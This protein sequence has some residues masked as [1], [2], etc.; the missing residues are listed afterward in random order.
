MPPS[1]HSSSS[2]SSSSHSSHSSHSSS[3][4]SYSSHSYN[5]HSS[6]SRSFGSS[7]YSGGRSS[8]SRSPSPHSSSSHSS[9]P[10]NPGSSSYQQQS[11]PAPAPAPRKPRVNQP[12]GFRP[13]GGRGALWMIGRRHDYVYYPFAWTDTSTGRHYE[14]GYYD[15]SGKRYENVAFEK[16]GKYENVLCHCPY[17]DQD[18]VLTLDAANV[19]H[20]LQ[21]PHC[22]GPME[23]KTQLDEYSGMQNASSA[24]PV[25]RTAEAPKKKRHIGLIIIGVLAGLGILGNIVED[26]TPTVTYDPPE[27]GYVI[28]YDDNSNVALFGETVYLKRTEEGEYAITNDSGAADKVMQWSNYDDSYYDP[29]SDCWIWCNTDMSPRV[30]QYWYEG[31]SSD[32]GDYGW[33]EHEDT[34]WYIEESEGRWIELPDSY[35]T[36]GLW[37]ISE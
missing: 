35:D 22:N 20:S 36:S 23:L 34:G 1:R 21:C 32:F 25:Y 13:V 26:K 28:N 37:Y 29:D 14:K 31:I 12:S 18:T 30:W 16:D 9:R 27:Q 8:Y 33:M 10:Y 19:S 17:C 4:R 6:S 3:S 24:E 7:S 5:S 11:R 15:E 2:H